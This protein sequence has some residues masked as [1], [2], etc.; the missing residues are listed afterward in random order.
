MRIPRD[1]YSLNIQHQTALA[2]YEMQQVYNRLLNILSDSDA[3]HA[4]MQIL[5]AGFEPEAW[6]E[7]IGY[8]LKSSAVYPYTEKDLM[9][10]WLYTAGCGISKIITLA[11]TTQYKVYDII[12]GY[13]PDKEPYHTLHGFWT[14]N[15]CQRIHNLDILTNTV[16]P[17][18]E[19]RTRSYRD[20]ILGVMKSGADR[21][22]NRGNFKRRDD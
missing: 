15:N 14:E 10:M 4:L 16:P 11:H 22:I 13:E 7:E 19:L 8:T 18:G 17:F 12:D 6:G 9:I 5:N 21:T 1:F 3:K 20:I 2:S